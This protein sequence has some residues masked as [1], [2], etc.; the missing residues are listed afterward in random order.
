MPG[1]SYARDEV[2]FREQNKTRM[3]TLAVAG[4]GPGR[5][6]RRSRGD[7]PDG[8]V[9]V[10]AGRGGRTASGQF[11]ADV[12]YYLVPEAEYQERNNSFVIDE[13]RHQLLQQGE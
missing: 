5:S 3:V 2:I 8:F 12:A 10:F 11:P 9:E 1:E 7:V 13:A 6:L 4:S